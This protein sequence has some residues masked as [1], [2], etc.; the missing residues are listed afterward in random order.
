MENAKNF[1]EEILKTEEAKVLLAAIEKPETEEAQI[2]AYLD[3]AKKLN[4]ELTADGILAYFKAAATGSEVDD[5]ELSQLVGS[6]DHSLCLDTF[7]HE[8]N[9]WLNDG[10]DVFITVYGD[11]YCGSSS[12]EKND[13]IYKMTHWI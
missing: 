8:E 12:K 5:E 11:Y 3:I 4:A 2:A 6:G 9:C 1:F 7:A 10:C 13:F